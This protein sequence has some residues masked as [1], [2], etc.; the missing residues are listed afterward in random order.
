MEAL[1]GFF[2]NLARH[3]EG[4]GGRGGGPQSVT[5]VELVAFSNMIDTS[6][7]LRMEMKHI[8]FRSDTN[9]QLLSDSKIL[10]YLVFKSIKT[11]EKVLVLGVACAR[12]K[13]K[14]KKTIENR[15]ACSLDSLVTSLT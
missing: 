3:R 5:R 6:F 1:P 2:S 7:M 15:L 8:S 4:G 14:K 13:I 10:F 11:Q 9:L 12:E